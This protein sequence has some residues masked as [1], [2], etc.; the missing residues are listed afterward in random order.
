MKEGIVE[1]WDDMEKVWRHTFDNE[2]RRG[3]GYVDD[4]TEPE[5]DEDACGVLFTQKPNTS[6]E[7]QEKMTQTMFETFNLRRFHLAT[8]A[9]LALVSSARTSGVVVD[10]G[11][12]V[13]H[14]L[15]VWD[16]MPLWSAHQIVSLGGHQLTEY[17]YRI[18]MESKIHF[19]RSESESLD[20]IKCELCRVSLNF[21]EEVDH[22]EGK[23]MPF[24]LPD[25]QIVTVH[26]QMIRCPEI[27]FNPSL[28][29]TS[30][31]DTLSS[32]FREQV[33]IHQSAH[34]AIQACPL[35]QHKCLYGN[36]VVAGS[37]TMFPLFED[38][39]QSEIKDLLQPDTKCRVIAPPER[40]ISAWIG[41]SI[42]ASLSTFEEKWMLGS[43]EGLSYEEVGPR[44]V[45]MVCDGSLPSC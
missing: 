16:G 39:L 10:S 15:P 3:V 13:T 36:V 33:G 6:A 22:F 35:E 25:R 1:N 19:I 18:L 45:H 12:D 4:K 9:V 14:V 11:L 21:N 5:H 26:N 23:E 37:N 34:T 42:I 24:E 27:L 2:L 8:D 30:T 38:R 28:V 44:I 17:L 7:H 31:R 43:G 32:R 40:M 29:D 20:K 41:G